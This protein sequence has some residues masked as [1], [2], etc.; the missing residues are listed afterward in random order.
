M[1]TAEDRISGAGIRADPMDGDKIRVAGINGHGI[2]AGSMTP[3]ATISPSTG[4]V[5]GLSPIGIKT[6]A[7]G[8]SGSWA[9]G[10]RCDVT[11]LMLARRT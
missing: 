4:K 6:A 7:P 9:C 2:S 8:V 5:N 1:V 10:S 11:H 3:A